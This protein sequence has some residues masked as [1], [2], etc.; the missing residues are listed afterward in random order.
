[1]EAADPKTF[2]SW[3]DAFQYPVTTVRGLEKQLRSELDTNRE[4]LRTLVGYHHLVTKNIPPSSTRRASASHARPQLIVTLRRASYR[5]LVDTAERIIDMDETFRLVGTK[6]ASVSGSCNSILVE[7]RAR[8]FHEWDA[9]TG[10][11]GTMAP[12]G[13]RRRRMHPDPSHNT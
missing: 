4:K 12:L 7:K 10:S 9:A 2:Q 13:S 11:Q 5:D 3:V 1:M 6:L 8:N